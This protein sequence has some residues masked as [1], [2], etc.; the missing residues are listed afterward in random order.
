[1]SN[2]YKNCENTGKILK[3]SCVRCHFVKLK[4]I[5]RALMRNVLNSCLRL[6]PIMIIQSYIIYSNK[7]DKKIL[8]NVLNTN[9]KVTKRARLATFT[10][11]IVDNLCLL[12]RNAAV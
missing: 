6:Y 12:Q 9:V 2:F 7:M 8:N 3:I 4:Y 10:I 5:S 11:S 1:M